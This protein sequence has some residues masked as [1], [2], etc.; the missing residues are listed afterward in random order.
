MSMKAIYVQSA[1]TQIIRALITNILTATSSYLM[2]FSTMKNGKYFYT[3]LAYSKC[4]LVVRT[5][6]IYSERKTNT[7]SFIWET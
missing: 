6:I 5:Y 1:N 3:H 4:H 7:I 2:Y